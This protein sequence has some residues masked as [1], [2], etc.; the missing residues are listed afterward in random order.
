MDIVFDKIILN[1]F[2]SVGHAEVDLN[3]RGFTIVKGKNREGAVEQSNGSGKSSIFDAIFWSLTG[4]T[5]RGADNV[6]NEHS[7]DKN[8]YCTLQFHSQ[9]KEYQITRS[10][11][12]ENA[13]RLYIDGELVSDQIKKSQE[14]L[15][16]VVPVISS[17]EVLGSIIILGQ[18]LPYKFSSFSPSK[19]KD[20]LETMSGASTEVDKVK[21][22]LDI[23]ESKHASQQNDAA[24]KITKNNG[25]ITGLE[26]SLAILNANLTREEESN[27]A[28]RTAAEI[29]S[30][31]DGLNAEIDVSQDEIKANDEK[32]GKLNI[33]STDLTST[34]SQYE[35]SY[36]AIVSQLSSIKSGNCPT[37]GRPFEV[38]E[39]T[40][41]NKE[42]LETKKVSFS[43]LISDAT[44]EI[45]RLN[46]EIQSI[47]SQNRQ[48]DAEISSKKVRISKLEEEMKTTDD[49]SQ[50]IANIKKDIDT[51]NAQITTL[52]VE[53]NDSQKISDKEQEYLDCVAYI[54]RQLSRDFKGYL[55]N[56]IIGFISSRAEYY[57]KYLFTDG[58]T[59]SIELSGNKIDI[60]S[61]GRMYENLSGGERQ[62]VDLIVQFSLKDVLVITS[63]F[64]C[65]LLV[66]DE[67]FDNLDAQGSESLIKLLVSEFSDINS[68]FIVTHH[69]EIDIPYDEE[70]TV[71]KEKDGISYMR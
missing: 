40:L 71:I 21:L 25:T 3:D 60:K 69:S 14:M 29:Q 54:K 62:R 70:I 5:V 49:S 22:K 43:K 68:V 16:K 27:S 46:T 66:L 19:R 44:A 10:K 31:I 50:R 18:G 61:G 9:D 12:K 34:K 32:L 17:P 38:T 28:R 41:R 37:C 24:V 7:E 11:G 45:N 56:E 6:V 13:C 53:N 20:L 58:S 35:A 65:N 26:S 57:S 2:L 15:E 1:D 67:A 33:D 4:S 55:L 51:L 63:G 36:S 48:K 59:V 64:S 23:E 47:Q 30:E 42:V 39:E 52:K 8:C